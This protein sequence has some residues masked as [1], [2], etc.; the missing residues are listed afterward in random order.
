[1]RISVDSAACSGHGVCYD[2]A[3]RLLDADEQGRG[4]VLIEEVPESLERDAR[5]AAA[6]CPE[7]AVRVGSAPR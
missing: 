1:M 4:V 6:S 2:I 5:T 7:G 3:P